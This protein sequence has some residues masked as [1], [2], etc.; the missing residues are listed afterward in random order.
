MGHIVNGQNKWYVIE[1]IQKIRI[2]IGR[3][4]HVRGGESVKVVSHI[5]PIEKLYNF[6]SSFKFM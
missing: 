6:I 1:Q 5:L 3:V 2:I 4:K